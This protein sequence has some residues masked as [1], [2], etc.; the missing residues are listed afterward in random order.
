MDED[1]ILP[2][3]I[4]IKN[5]PLV[6]NYRRKASQA[7][8]N[9]ES[10]EFEWT[11]VADT[12][13]YKY[14][15]FIEY[16]NSVFFHKIKKIEISMWGDAGI[17]TFYIDANGKSFYEQNFREESDGHYIFKSDTSKFNLMVNLLDYLNFTKLDSHYRKQ[18]TDNST[19]FIKIT[20]DNNQTKTIQDYGFQ[21]TYGLIRLYKLF[22]SIIEGKK[23][24]TNKNSSISKMSYEEFVLKHFVKND[25]TKLKPQ[26]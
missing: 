4:E 2:K 7:Y 16:N 11:L 10:L 17:S 13:I 15:A 22:Y 24:R 23:T 14:D 20:Y 25:K 26:K 6:L 5:T 12:L 1:I 18:A 19:A 3:V 8:L 9:R 21:G